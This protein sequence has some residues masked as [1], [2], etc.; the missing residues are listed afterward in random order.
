MEDRATARLE[1]QDTEI[2][3]TGSAVAKRG[4]RP[5]PNPNSDKIDWNQA[6]GTAGVA[7]NM[8][9]AKFN[10]DVAATPS[11]TSDYVVFGLNTPGTTA[12][13]ASVTGTFTGT[14]SIGWTITI[15]GQMFTAGASNT[16]TTFLAS[17]SASTTATDFAARV[18]AN[19]NVNGVT[20]VANSPGA[21]QVTLAMYGA[22]GTGLPVSESGTF[23]SFAGGATSLTGGVDGQAN[24]VA[25]NQLYSGTSGLCTGNGTNPDV[26]WAYNTSSASGSI[27]TS[28]IIKF[29]STGSMVA[30]VESSATATTLHVLRW[31]AGQGT[32]SFDAVTPDTSTSTGSTY[33]SCLADA[34]KSCMF[35]LTLDSGATDTNSSPFYDYDKDT[36]YVGNDGG[37]L[38]QVTNVFS[39]STAP[40]LSNTNGFG[41]NTGFGTSGALKCGAS[42]TT[43]CIQVAATVLTGPVYDSNSGKIFL[44][45]ANG[46]LYAVNLGASPTTTSLAVGSGNAN[47]GGIVDPPIVDSFNQR[48]FAYSAS[49]V[50]NPAGQTQAIDTRA[51]IV[52]ADTNTPLGN[53]VAAFLGLGNQANAT[54]AFD[55]HSGAFDDQYFSGGGLGHL[56]MCGT[57]NLSKAPQLWAV[58]FLGSL[59]SIAVTASG[60]YSTLPTS[61]SINN[62]GPATGGN[63]TVTSNVTGTVTSLS[64]ITA[65]GNANSGTCTANQTGATSSLTGGTFTTAATVTY[66]TNA[67][68]RLTAISL[69]T[70]GIYSAGSVRPTGIA[71]CSGQPNGMSTATTFGVVTAATVNAAGSG[72]YLAP[73]VSFTGGTVT[74]TAATAT[75]VL[76]SGVAMAAGTTW[77]VA[78]NALAISATVNLECS[79][80]SELVNGATDRIFFG[81]GSAATG[82]ITSDNVSNAGSAA[83]PALA[84]PVTQPSAFGGTSGIVVDNVSASAQASSIYYSQLAT[85]TATL[86]VS[87]GVRGGSGGAPALNIL[88]I[89]TSSDHGLQIGD[90]VTTAGFGSSQCNVTRTVIQIPSTTVFRVVGLGTGTT[91]GTVGTGSQQNATFRSVKL[92]QSNLN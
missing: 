27:K 6:L 64:G 54:N 91:C 90:S 80:I 70:G 83:L 86:A 77:Q 79:P 3:Q 48:V 24:L 84:A 43:G 33:I 4:K 12:V 75:A 29:D 81:Y 65:S 89:T 61:A 32:S 35:N 52:Q 78:S 10:F 9:P 11:C 46:L 55:I 14:T 30:F 44:G 39:T 19:S 49:N 15:N 2:S 47:G 76:A 82:A 88:T 87:A 8:F 58:P 1:D 56:M 57:S 25:F 7:Q 21:G 62:A 60:G 17:A 72:Y 20:A 50:L 53:P 40:A 38:Y 23:F 85:S 13:W 16:G 71:A 18:N 42:G 45:G 66:S 34:T 37:R 69:A 5:R 31:K 36:L 59:A 28:P 73:A 74:T 63:G 67:N 41:V 22:T 92:T 26:M 68:G 51:L